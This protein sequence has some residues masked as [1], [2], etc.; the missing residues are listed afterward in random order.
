M[1]KYF[2]L[3]VT[4]ALTSSLFA[5]NALIPFINIIPLSKQEFI[6]LDKKNKSTI[7]SSNYF[8]AVSFKKLDITC[9]K[10]ASRTPEKCTDQSNVLAIKIVT[11]PDKSLNGRLLQFDKSLT[12]HQLKDSFLSEGAFHFFVGKNYPFQKTIV[13][14]NFP[15]GTNALGN[16]VYKAFILN[17]APKDNYLEYIGAKDLKTD[18]K[19]YITHLIKTSP[20]EFNL[21]PIGLVKYSVP[22]LTMK[23]E[24]NRLF[25]S[26]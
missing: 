24:K 10:T 20:S 2:V 15:L 18:I 7:D 22:Q 26:H 5:K 16:T 4:F 23:D 3:V 8:Y 13:M 25:H 19:K 9:T 6:V 21:T 1:K 14:W 12:Y 11:A 17:I